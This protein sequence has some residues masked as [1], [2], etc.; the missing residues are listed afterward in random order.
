VDPLSAGEGIVEPTV[1]VHLPVVYWCLVVPISSGGLLIVG[2]VP[3]SL[4]LSLSLSL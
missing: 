1:V 2:G 4:L 3:R